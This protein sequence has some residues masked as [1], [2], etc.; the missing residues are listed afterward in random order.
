MIT[1]IIIFDFFT[2][3]SFN[4]IIIRSCY[5]SVNSSI[6]TRVHRVTTT[7][8]WSYWWILRSNWGRWGSGRWTRGNWSWWC[9]AMYWN[10]ILTLNAIQSSL[11][12]ILAS[13]ATTSLTTSVSTVWITI[14]LRPFVTIKHNHEFIFT[15]SE[16]VCQLY[17]LVYGKQWLVH[18]N[19]W[20]MVSIQQWHCLL[21]YLYSM[22]HHYFWVWNIIKQQE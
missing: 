18:C 4:H 5:N 1:E 11:R 7:T 21:Y 10:C 20:C 14:L 17:H 2:Y 13:T 9:A 22:S 8:W 3:S 19:N 16:R 12:K 6:H 15:V